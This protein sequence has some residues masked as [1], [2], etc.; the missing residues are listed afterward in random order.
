MGTKNRVVR[1][2]IVFVAGFVPWALLWESIGAVQAFLTGVVVAAAA[3][4]ALS[5][6]ARQTHR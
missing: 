5:R 6:S 1:S 4:F 3:G 2:I